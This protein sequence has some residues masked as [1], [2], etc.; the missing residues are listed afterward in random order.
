[1]EA[2]NYGD[3]GRLINRNR[4]GGQYTTQARPTIS[5]RR[6]TPSVRLSVLSSGLSPSS[7]YSSGPSPS[8][9]ATRLIIRTPARAAC[10]A[11]TMSTTLGQSTAYASRSNSTRSPADS[12]G[13]MLRP[14]TTTRFAVTKA[15]K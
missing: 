2:A 15:I 7:Q 6:N 9:W 4:D 13:N 12:A 11:S 3:V 10:L 1:M 5:S 8:Q 14:R